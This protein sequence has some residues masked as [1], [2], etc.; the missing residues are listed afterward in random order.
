MTPPPVNREAIA[1]L[2][3]EAE[4]QATTSTAPLPR[5]TSA[6]RN[7]LS[8]LRS[9]YQTRELDPEDCKPCEHC[10]AAMTTGVKLS[11]GTRIIYEHYGTCETYSAKLRA[12]RAAEH[13]AQ[14]AAYCEQRSNLP[15]ERLES[16]AAYVLAFP[17]LSPADRGAVRLCQSF[18]DACREEVPPDGLTLH[19][20]PGTGKTTL[21]MALASEL[22]TLR[23]D[24]RFE[25]A[26]TLYSK[27]LS[28]SRN[29][30]LDDEVRRIQTVKV[31]LLD[32][33]G[34]EKA[35]PWWVDTV[36]FAIVNVRYRHKLPL[37]VTTNYP[38]AK[39]EE[40]YD[41]AR[42][43]REEAHSA[44][45]LIDRLKQRSAMLPFGNG[46]SHRE[47]GWSFLKK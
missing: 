29:E 17:D 33:L 6:P 32:D 1:R 30:R 8:L 4:R 25:D 41:H 26:P 31:L 5:P 3:Q 40:K 20:A 22:L 10:G 28:A 24:V 37:I 2:H 18:A 14:R 34:R 9:E 7:G 15:K 44:T 42:N 36:L 35:T 46:K 47:P 39:L 45:A 27:L 43:E 38:W 23:V 11:T 19:G 21:A 13:E 16:V 12:Q